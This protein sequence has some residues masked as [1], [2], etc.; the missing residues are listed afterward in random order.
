MH[1]YR[2]SEGK[3]IVSY[4]ND[5]PSQNFNDSIRFQLKKSINGREM[6]IVPGNKSELEG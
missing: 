1:G 3:F 4:A 2:F 5:D 6:K